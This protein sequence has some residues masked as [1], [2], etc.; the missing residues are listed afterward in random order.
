MMLTVD[1]MKEIAVKT[2]KEYLGEKYPG[3]EVEFESEVDENS[4][5]TESLMISDHHVMGFRIPVKTLFDKYRNGEDIETYLKV[6]LGEFLK[7]YEIVKEAYA[8]F[9]HVKEDF[10]IAKE[11]LVP[12]VFDAEARST[13]LENHPYRRIG[14]IALEYHLLYE[15][16]GLGMQMSINHDTIQKWGIT[17]EKLMKVMFDRH[18]ENVFLAGANDMEYCIENDKEPINL[19]KPGAKSGYESNYVFGCESLYDFDAAFIFNDV[20]MKKVADVLKDDFYISPVCTDSVVVTPVGLWK[21]AEK[22]AEIHEKTRELIMEMEEDRT[23]LPEQ[24]MM[25]NRELGQVVVVTE[26]ENGQMVGGMK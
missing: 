16:D 21:G 19:L 13:L 8:F 25:Y 12:Y 9:D 17:E 1:Q 11:Y 20:I 24:L 22:I 15:R 6:K 2:V 18:Q 3:I 26:E 10:S 7:E 14:D 23:K 4:V 5:T